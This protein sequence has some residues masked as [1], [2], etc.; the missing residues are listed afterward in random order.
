MRI[1]AGRHKGRK[2]SAPQG[3]D[4]RPTSDRARETLFN[5]L[6]HGGF[7]PGGTSPLIEAAV[8]DVFCG[9]GALGLEALS[10]GAARVVFMDSSKAALAAAQANAGDLDE[11]AACHFLQNDGEA[12]GKATGAFTLVFL[13]PPYGKGLGGK[14]LSA[15]SHEGWIAPGALCILETGKDEVFVPP[16][17]FR[18]LKE[19]SEGAAK[20]IFLKYAP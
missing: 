14:S 5:I 8:L 18:V 9:S 13:D 1:I 15:L 4:T 20:I 6:V 11:Q 19:R 7:H 16:T 12:P 10:R 2:L 3:S 17:G